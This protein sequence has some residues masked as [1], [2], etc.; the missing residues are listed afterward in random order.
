MIELLKRLFEDREVALVG[1]AKYM[2]RMK[3]GDEIN[4]HETVVRIN[5]SWES[6]EKYRDNI[7]NRTDVL[8][9]CLIEKPANAGNIDIEKYR[10]SQIK[11]I[12]APPASDMKGI[13]NKTSLHHLIDVKKV[14]SLSREIP[15]RVVDHVFHNQLSLSVDC[16][17]NTGYVA[18][19]DI[20]RMNPKKLSI[21]GFSFYLDGFVSG[22]KSGIIGEQNKTEEEFADQC[23]NSKRHVQKNMWQFAKRTLLENKR[24]SL[25]PELEKILNLPALDKDLYEKAK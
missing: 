10:E 19:Y 3:L 6:I 12:C 9:S 1:P 5:R 8:Y 18:I 13:S 23:F 20:L 21:Y 4:S 2:E 24:V 16:R 11:L 14:E 22:V 25:D 15:V 17:P 7:G